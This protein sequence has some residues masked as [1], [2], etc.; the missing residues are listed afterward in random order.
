[1]EAEAGFGVEPAREPP[2][3]V[4]VDP[5]AQAGGSSLAFEAGQPFVPLNG[6][7]LGGQ[8]SLELIGVD[9]SANA[10][11]CTARVVR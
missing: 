6:A 8:G 9:R 7:D 3:A 4:P 1:V 10:A 5:G 11:T 2:H